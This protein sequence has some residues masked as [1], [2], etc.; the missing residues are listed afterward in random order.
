MT[1]SG[2]Y[3]SVRRFLRLPSWMPGILC[4]ALCGAVLIAGVTV[5]FGPPERPPNASAAQ[6]RSAVSWALQSFQLSPPFWR[7]QRRMVGIM[8]EN[9]QGARPYHAGLE[10]ALL[11]EEFLVE[12]GITRFVA[13][14]D[15]DDLPE[16]MGPVRSLRPYFVDAV[17]PWTSVVL[18][19]GG[20][21]EAFAH[22]DA[23]DD[24]TAINALRYEFEQ[25]FLR[26]SSIAA[27]HNLFTD[28]QRVRA[29]LEGRTVRPIHW[30]PYAVGGASAEA[31]ASTIAIRYGSKTHD[32]A[33]QYDPADGR[34]ARQ[35]LEAVE[36][37]PRNVLILE[38]PI[39][40]VGEHGRLTIPVTGSGDLLLFR[41]G[42]MTQGIWHK[43]D[44]QP[45]DFTTTD[46]ATLR[47]AS[48]QT[49]MMVIPDLGKV[50]WTTE[51][52]ESEDDTDIHS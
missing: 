24:L 41:S 40:G 12:A 21:P 39:T 46:G 42:V 34:Y 32:V 4:G 52:A 25:Y 47:L 23:A 2:R 6:E 14:F 22:A 7:S 36:Q 48:G 1:A 50:T 11:V 9:H 49:W 28:D 45:F 51:S 31:Y 19:A 33:Y 26:D 20:S 13:F 44:D 30:P 27:P 10:R 38:M 37:R 16:R 35:S 29:L 3:D 5:F 17:R 8:I 18:H 15:L 43:E